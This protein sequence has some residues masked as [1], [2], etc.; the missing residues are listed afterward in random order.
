MYKVFNENKAIIFSQ[1]IK[2]PARLSNDLWIRYH[3]FSTLMVQL[4]DFINKNK[5]IYVDCGEDLENVFDLFQKEYKYI[6]AAGGLVLSPEG[7][8]LIIRRL[9]R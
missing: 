9:D 1:D 6:E 2:K 4:E 3:D 5:N 8:L 7:K